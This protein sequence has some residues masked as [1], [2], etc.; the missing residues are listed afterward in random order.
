[1]NLTWFF[2]LISIG[3]EAF[4]EIENPNEQLL[5]MEKQD[6]ARRVDAA[7]DYL[8]HYRV[9]SFWMLY[10]LK[11]PNLLTEFSQNRSA[12]GQK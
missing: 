12:E 10:L 3:A 5:Y 7:A 2:S 8:G 4:I 6:A 11:N 1:M 9:K